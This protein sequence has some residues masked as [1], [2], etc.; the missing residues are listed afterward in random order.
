MMDDDPRQY[1]PSI[2]HRELSARTEQALRYRGG[3]VP[4]YLCVPKTTPPPYTAFIC[5]Q[6]H[7]T[8]MHN[9][10]AVAYEDEAKPIVAEGD[11][12]FGLGCMARGI[13]ALCIEQRSFGERCHHAIGEGGHRFYSDAFLAGLGYVSGES[14]I[15]AAG[16]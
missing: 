12:D 13:V 5:L 9:S 16:E 1:S 7:T 8:G 6:G 3:D 11:R 4:A 15:V 14:T 10:I 2:Y